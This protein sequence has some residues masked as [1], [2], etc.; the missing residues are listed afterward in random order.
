ME[1]REHHDVH[2]IRRYADLRE[3]FHEHVS[4]L[5]HPEALAE[6]RLEEGANAGLQENGPTVLA[7]EQRAAGERDAAMLVRGR[8]LLP[9]RLRAV[10][11]HRAAVEPLRV[12]F[13][14][15]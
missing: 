6:L 7:H 13:D 8:P 1:M 14:R 4:I 9:H 3:R 11:E 10:A 5:L 15:E 2:V 12:A